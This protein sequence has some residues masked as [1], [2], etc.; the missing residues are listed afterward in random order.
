[1]KPNNQKEALLYYLQEGHE[2]DFLVAAN[3]LG[4]SQLT[5]RIAE[6]RR[7]GWEFTKRT[8]KGKNRYGHPYRKIFYSS[9]TNSKYPMHIRRAV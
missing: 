6:L 3:T 8:E 7:E 2:V 5:G 9:P 1:M 4:I